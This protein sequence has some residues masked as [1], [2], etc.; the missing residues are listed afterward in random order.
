MVVA[1]SAASALVA[2]RKGE[3]VYS[4]SAIVSTFF[5]HLMPSPKQHLVP[6]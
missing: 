6:F 3:Y 1:A 2:V 4:S 5:V